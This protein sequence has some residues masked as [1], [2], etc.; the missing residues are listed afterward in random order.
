M[1]QKARV[2]FW[3]FPSYADETHRL[4]SDAVQSC[5][6]SLAWPFPRLIDPAPSQVPDVQPVSA[7]IVVPVSVS[8]NDVTEVRPTRPRRRKG[9][10]PESKAVAPDHHDSYD[11]QTR[12]PAY[13]RLRML[14]YEHFSLGDI[15]HICS[16]IERVSHAQGKRLTRRNRAARRRKPNAF[17]WLDANWDIIAAYA[18]DPAV[19]AVLGDPA[20]RKAK[21]GKVENS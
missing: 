12:S 18:Y 17:H 4:S 1:E 7:D 14:G 6:T 15:V 16:V 10:G 11:F 5:A 13:I 19:I 20:A 3:P 2:V 21:H 8:A 9:T